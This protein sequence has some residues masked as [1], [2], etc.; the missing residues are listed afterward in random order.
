VS[1]K[2]PARLEELGDFTTTARVVPITILAAC[3]GV[4]ATYVASAL[5]RLIALFTNVFF[6]QRLSSQPASPAQ[7]HLGPW[8]VIV[9]VAG[10]A[11]C[12][13]SR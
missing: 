11:G 4:L 13:E 1:P 8:A 12:E 10:D 3:I 7:H 5:L 6:F 2:H 9:P